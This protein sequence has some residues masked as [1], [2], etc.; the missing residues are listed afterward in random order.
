V[1]A[2]CARC[3]GDFLLSELLETRNGCCPRCGWRL[4]EDWAAVLLEE[5]ARADLAQRHLAASLRRLR[6]LP[7]NLVVLPGAVVRTVVDALGWEQPPDDELVADQRKRLA[8]LARPWLNDGTDV[9]TPRWR[10]RLHKVTAQPAA[11]VVR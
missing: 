7:G 6:S 9:S 8:E 10:R 5:A 1:E 3:T 2:R 11:M 4:T